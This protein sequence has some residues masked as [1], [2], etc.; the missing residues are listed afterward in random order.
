MMKSSTLLYSVVA[1]LKVTALFYLLASV[2]FAQPWAYDFGTGTGTANNANSGSG[3]TTFFPSTPSGGGTYRVRI[4]TGGGSLG[5]VN[6]GTTL[7]TATEAQL[8]ATTGTSTNKFTVYGWTSPSTR[9][10]QRFR[11]RNTSAGT[12]ALYIH[13]GSGAASTIYQDNTAAANY[14][15]SL[16]VLLIN[17]SAG[18]ITT[19]QRRISGSF[20]T[21]SSSGIAKDADQVLEI[22]ANNATTSTTY[23][24]GTGSNT[25]NAGSWDLW[26]DGTKISPSGGWGGTGGWTTGNNIG[27]F[28]FFAESSASNSAVMYIDDLEYSNGMP[29]SPTAASVS[30]TS[31]TICT[32]GTTAALGG[33]TPSVGTGVWSIIGGGAGTFSASTSPSSTFTHTSGTVT[34]LRWTITNGTCTSTADVALTINASVAPSVTT[35]I[36]TGTNPTC[37]G[38][39]VTFTATPTNGGT[40]TYQW[41]KNGTDISGATSVTYTGVA[42]TDFVNGDLIR[43][44]MTSTA[45]CAS[46]MTATSTAITMTVNAPPTTS[47][48]GPDQNICTAPGTATMAGNAPS[49]G[50]GTWSQM[51]GPSATITTPGSETTTVTGMTTVGTYVFRWTIAN[52]PCTA[53]TD[54]ISVVVGVCEYY[55][56]ATGNVTDAIWSDTP[57]GIAG[58]ATFTNATS[59]TVQSGNVVTNVANTVVKSLTVATGGT[60]VLNGSTTFD[61]KGNS[62]TIAGTMTANDNSTFIIS[63]AT[64]STLAITGSVDFYDFT[65]DPASS[66]TVTGT[67]NV[68]GTLSITDGVFDASGA[69]VALTSNISGTGRL[70]PVGAGASYTGDMTVQRYIPAGATNWRLL[71]SPVSGETVN[72]WKDDFYTAGFPG[73]HS[74]GFSDPPQ[75]GILWPSIRWYDETN[76][77]ASIDSGL[78]GAT[79]T[80][81]SLAQGQGF[82]AWCGDGLNTTAAFVID[83]T[84]PPIVAT[85]PINLPMSFTT[86][87]DPMIDGYNLCS[88]PLPSPILFS[89]IARASVNDNVTFFNPATNFGN[90]AVWDISLN[91]GTNNAT[92]T[93]QSSQGFYLKANG[94]GPAAQVE[95]ADK[96]VGNNGGLFGGS[97]ISTFNGL[98]LKVSSAINTFRDET[99]VVFSAGTSD[100]DSEDV[101]KVIF[102]HPDAPQIATRTPDGSLIAINAYGEY[103]T[104]ISIPV[105]V[106][107]AISG[108]YTITIS[109]TENLGLSCLVLEDMTTGTMTPMLEGATYSFSMEAADDATAERFVLH[110]SAPVVL[111]TEATRCYGDANGTGTVVYAGTGPMDIS[112]TNSTGVVLDQQTITEGSATVNGLAAGEYNV[113][114]SST[115]ACGSLS[116][117]FRIEEPAAMEIVTNVVDAN[118][119]NENG[120]VTVA[121]LGGTAP[122]TYLWSNGNT[123]AELSAPVGNHSVVVTDGSGCTMEFTDIVI[124]AGIGPVAIATA[125]ASTVLV[126]NEVFFTNGSEDADEYA[127]DFGDGNTS[128]E[129]EPVHAWSIPGAYTVVLTVSDGNCTDT[130]TTEIT[131][132]TISNIADVATAAPLN[133]WFAND[134]FVVDHS[135]SNGKPVTIDIMDATGRLHSTRQVAGSPARV[136]IATDGL[137][138]GIWFVRV[139]NAQEQ[140]TFRVPL[141][142]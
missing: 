117:S 80:A 14:T 88:N 32:A 39:S 116:T 100:R 132:E 126:N 50:T 121:V 16:A 83:V 1:R 48:A 111:S 135:F 131:V 101:G 77:F 134:K 55:S 114:V 20:S 66:L 72:E 104:D 133:A 6:P 86:T 44:V 62:A 92:D 76:T 118:C 31:Q 33:N 81:Q 74:P 25:L 58:F 141:V 57:S 17:Y 56:R 38:S 108:T 91:V 24:Q 110:A 70:G 82:A 107:V 94:P 127:W 106:D 22:Y 140:R 87:G 49:I 90:A 124:G 105:M 7:G 46:P 12:G 99:V 69:T 64:T 26:V 138:T 113:E 136:N 67:V 18:A 23:C 130:W 2:G 8:V 79:S 68:R 9:A 42:D 102:G 3:N 36:T 115:S 103:T 120:T 30:P 84:G 47:A 129:M 19:V 21:I 119:P 98:R 75:S 27:G 112:W 63:E 142:R 5:L 89:N 10:Y 60:L 93:I 29:V 28:G 52:S 37:S 15:N 51:S 78:V 128:N 122:F 61:V 13:V 95:E 11:L 40:P 137:N 45:T 85:S 123:G 59:M 97:Q 54:D 34:A 139:T 71:G 41:T 53:S 109:S 4:G 96:V 35:A 73:S 65:A 125:D 43:V